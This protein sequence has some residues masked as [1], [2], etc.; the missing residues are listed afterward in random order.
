M[1]SR[2]DIGRV[3][4][5]SPPN[6]AFPRF[7]NCGSGPRDIFALGGWGTDLDI[8]EPRSIEPRSIPLGEPG[9]FAIGVDVRLDVPAEAP[10]WNPPFSLAA[11][12]ALLIVGREKL[13][14]GGVIRA[15][16]LP[17]IADLSGTAFTECT[18]S[19][20]LIWLGE[21]RSALRPTCC[22]L[23]SVLR[24]TAVKPFGWRIFA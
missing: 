23:T 7:P 17:S 16:E 9:R 19:T 6:E 15:R 20:R 21:T 22:P 2:C 11:I 12:D 3:S 1:F 4:P 18:G 8:I 24:E 10:L 14:A 5:R 13:R